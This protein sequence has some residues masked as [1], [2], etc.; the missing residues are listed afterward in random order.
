MHPGCMMFRSCFIWFQIKSF[1]KCQ[2]P[3]N[4]IQE[5]KRIFVQINK[6]KNIFLNI[7]N[8][9]FYAKL[10]SSMF[11]CVKTCIFFKPENSHLPLIIYQSSLTILNL[12]KKNRPFCEFYSY[13][14]VSKS[15]EK[16]LLIPSFFFL[17]EK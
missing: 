16:Y 11:L 15:I 6:I 1:D 10:I 4:I 14:Y 5:R 9:L 8:G 2:V 17:S 7:L 13:F 12:D 3:K